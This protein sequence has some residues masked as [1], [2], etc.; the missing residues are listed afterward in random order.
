MKLDYIMEHLLNEYGYFALFIGTFLE[1]ETILILAGIAAAH[2]Y[3]DL[4]I[5]IIVAFIG[6][7]F[8]DQLWYFL[9]R[10]YG[11]AILNKRPKW[12]KSA[13]KAL[14]YLKRNPDLWVLTFRFMYGLR[15]IMP[16]AIGI[17]GYSPKRYMILNAIGAIIW[18]IVLGGASYY[19]GSI[20]LSYLK[21]YELIFLAA[22]AIIILCFWLRRFFKCRKESKE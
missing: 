17:S 13:D 16:V 2:H 8:G 6:S 22:I 15:T 3:L 19:F 1:G 10:H 21:D 11:I 20:V 5:V 4:K 9:G 14:I 12:Q 7:Y 18:S